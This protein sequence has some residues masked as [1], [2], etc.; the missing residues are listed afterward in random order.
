MTPFEHIANLISIVIGLGITHLLMN[1]YRLIQV[2]DRVKF[3][4]LPALWA[5]IIFMSM[6][7]WWWYFFD[8]RN[9]IEHWNFFYLLFVLMSPVAQFMAA[10][11]VLPEPSEGGEQ[12]DLRH[13]YYRDGSYFFAMMAAS[14]VLDAIR[15]GLESGSFSNFGV[16]TN[17]V[18]AVLV[19]SL[20]WTKRETYHVFVTLVVWGLFLWFVVSAALNL[21]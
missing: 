20:A 14:P 19:G 2:R 8:L 7:E 3:Y 6:V 9:Q 4:W 1:I 17:A 12:M 10:A 5:G 13:Y 21:R 11:F 15:R 16:I 18:S